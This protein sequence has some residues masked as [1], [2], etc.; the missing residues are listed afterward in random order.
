MRG[1]SVEEE[2]EG[3]KKGGEE[4][5][6]EGGK[7]RRE[8]RE[9]RGGGG[10]SRLY[11]KEHNYSTIP[12][13]VVKYRGQRLLIFDILIPT[14]FLSTASGF[15]PSPVMTIAPRSATYSPL[16]KVWIR[17]PIRS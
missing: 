17:P 12:V 10:L 4:G 9:E 7:G 8:G 2:G 13:P 14:C 15:P 1:G 6:K 11:L 16:L 5:G 3:G